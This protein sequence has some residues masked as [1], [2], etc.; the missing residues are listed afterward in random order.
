MKVLFVAPVEKI[1]KQVYT[2][3]NETLALLSAALRAEEH[4]I[5]ALT[6]EDDS[7]PFAATAAEF[8]PEIVFIEARTSHWW[9]VRKAAPAI[10]GTAPAAPVILY[11]PH[12]GAA[13]RQCLQLEGVAGLFAGEVEETIPAFVR[14][15]T[16]GGNQYK[17]PGFCFQIEGVVYRNEPAPLVDP[18]ALPRPDRSLFPVAEWAARLPTVGVDFWAGRGGLFDQSFFP[19]AS[20]TIEAPAHGGVV[21]FKSVD[22][23]LREIDE[24]RAGMRDSLTLLGF[25]DEAFTF[26]A[27]WTAEFCAKYAERFAIPWWCNTR[28]EYLTDDLARAIAAAG[29]RQVQVPVESGNHYLRTVVLGHYTPRFQILN[30]F[31]AIRRAGMRA[32]ASNLIGLPYE[33]EDMIR[34][35]LDLN[36]RIQPYWVVL[37]LFRPLPGTN[38]HQLCEQKGWLLPPADDAPPDP[39]RPDYD[40][41][42]RLRYPWIR[43]QRLIWYYENF[44]RLVYAKKV[45]LPWVMEKEESD[46]DPAEWSR[47]NG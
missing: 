17:T 44:I 47:K 3:Y 19:R 2:P 35:T 30:A 23:L 46:Y 37:A 20:Q 24:V 31:N 45:E 39:E 14:A 26:D 18:A 41:L 1:F 36:R 5:L 38:L 13:I 6:P 27:E 25:Q 15:V 16:T 34:Q 40:R 4:E 21:R 9:I 7:L 22:L 8:A 42:L 10:H 11:G 33:N 43:R 32:V 29:C 28:A 12:A